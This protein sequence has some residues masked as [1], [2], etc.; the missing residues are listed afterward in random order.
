MS[1]VLLVTGATGKQGGSVIKALLS[2]QASDFTILAVTRD[3]R[4]A[5]AKRIAALAPSIKLVEGNLD[6]VPALFRAAS[7]A[8]SPIW[9]VYS[10]QVAMGKGV[11]LEG[12]ERQGKALVDE[13]IK[14]GVSHFVYSSVE[15]GGRDRSWDNP[16]PVP[17]FQ[18]KHKVEHHLRDS[19]AKS[20]MGWTI[21][22]PTIFMDNLEPGFFGKVF[23][24]AVRDTLQDKPLQWIATSDIG[25][26]AAAA[27]RSPEEFNQRAIGLVGDTLTFEQLNTAFNHVTGKPTGTT[28]SFLGSALKHGVVEVGSMVKWFADEGYKADADE[29]QR[30]NPS[31]T[32]MEKWLKN[33]AFAEGK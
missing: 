33:S 3:A 5:G 11:T 23:M 19:A 29:A 17:H 16:T 9:G 10:V 22:R 32:S 24:T 6:N 7:K 20:S 30:I 21:L 27:F 31:L 1:R 28:F 13:A 14:S 8:A 15:R 12:E 25:P 4:S 2:Q 26:F 18:T